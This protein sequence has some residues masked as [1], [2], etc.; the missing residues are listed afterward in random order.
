M[1][2]PIM[3]AATPTPAAAAPAAPDAGTP[4]A[5]KS[6]AV[7]TPVPDALKTPA[8]PTA[9][10]KSILEQAGE[11]TATGQ[12]VDKSLETWNKAVEAHLAEPTPETKAAAEAA[13]ADVKKAI[14][15]AK[16]IPATVSVPE[17]YEMKLGENQT[18][19]ETLLA[20]VTPML[21]EAQLSNEQLNKLTPVVGKIQ[22]KAITAYVAS[23]TKAETERAEAET[24]ATKE[25]LGASYPEKLALVAKARDRFFSAESKAIL[26][27]HGNSLSLIQDM[28]KLGTLISEGKLVD[29]PA[30]TA[31][32]DAASALFPS[33]AT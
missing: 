32:K 12:A 6:A 3:P 2:E 31:P 4:A 33:M 27:K 14:E 1:T 29:G 23:Q 11:T 8:T 17:K 9:P 26:S 20:D 28:I 13:L 18:L 21:K 5:G 25:A 16:A 10:A 22:E 24:K 30:A 19:D 7:V 15:A